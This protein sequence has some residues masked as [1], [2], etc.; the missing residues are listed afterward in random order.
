MKIENINFLQNMK[1]VKTIH[2]VLIV[3]SCIA[4]VFGLVK[5]SE[6]QEAEA[7][8]TNNI[9]ISILNT[10]P[11]SDGR[12][13][14]V[15]NDFEIANNTSATI[16]YIEI[17]STFIDESGKYIGSLVSSYGSYGA[18]LEVGKTITIE[19]YLKESASSAS[20]NKLFIELYNNGMDN[21]TV[22]HEITSIV[23]GD[24]YIPKT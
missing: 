10:T 1:N 20:T 6:V 14:Y 4:F 23:W 21:L 9:E 19:T 8:N 18:T 5:S 24:G 11:K 7:H 16:D 15:Y 13:Y 17:T 12:Y 22:T 2:I 3:I